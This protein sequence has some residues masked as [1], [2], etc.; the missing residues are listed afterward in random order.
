[1][2]NPLRICLAF[3]LHVPR[4]T[5]PADQLS[6]SLIEEAAGQIMNCDFPVIVLA[7]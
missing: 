2:N 4:E 5:L 3:D 1:M 7:R 6:H